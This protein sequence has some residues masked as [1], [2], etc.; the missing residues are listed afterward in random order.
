MLKDSEQFQVVAACDEQLKQLENMAQ[1]HSIPKENLFADENVFWQEKRAD[2]VIISTRDN[3]HVQQCIKAMRLGYD[4]LLEKPISD[5]R[6][7]IETLL[8]VQQETGRIVVVCHVMRYS[9]AIRELERILGSGVVGDIIAIDHYERVAYWHQAQ[10][11][12]R[13][14]KQNAGAQYATILAKCCHD[15]DLIQHFANARCKTVSSIGGLVYFRPEN[16]P[17]DSADKCYQCKYMDTCRF[18]AKKLYIDKW[19]EDGRPAFAYPYFRV[20]I[21][22]PNTE[23]S[24]YE[25]IRNTVFGDCVYKCGIESDPHVVDH[26]MVQ[27]EFENG[28][29]ASLKMVFAAQGGRRI[30]FFTTKGDL[31]Y[32]EI[33]DSIEVKVHG[34]AP[35]II[36]VSELGDS[37]VGHGGGD[38]GLI[39]SLYDILTGVKTEYTT[40]SES[41]ESHLMGIC[42]EESRLNGGVLV[43][44]HQ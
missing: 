18:S 8:Q 23:E 13:T 41:V 4:V 20:S 5:S 38:V 40:L 7:D 36:K 22:N 1:L 26:Q 28:V 35:Q 19:I 34:E 32:D 30:H 44:V 37:L 17:A 6:E 2:V 16:A 31:C 29:I 9:I 14:Q 33:K 11:Y 3:D 21:T 42:A 15:L 24:L 10:A 43:K 39:Q 12:V 27:M 25:G